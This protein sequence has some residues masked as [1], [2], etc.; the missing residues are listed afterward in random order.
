LLLGS[1]S[2]EEHLASYRRVDI[3]LDSFPQG[4]GVSTWESLH[5][6]V[7]VV[8]KLGNAMASRVG[9]AI[10]SAIGMADWVAADNDQY[11]EIALRSAPDRLKA[12][13][14]ELPGLIDRRCSPA[15]YTRAVEQAYRAMWEKRCGELQN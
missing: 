4:G 10:L 13:R 15:A 6:G 7:P 12:I 1:T 3:C 11:V 5:M 8:A 14:H 2:R 9:G